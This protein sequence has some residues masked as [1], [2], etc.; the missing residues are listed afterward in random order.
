[1]SG[2]KRATAILCNEGLDTIGK[3]YVAVLKSAVAVHSS[4]SVSSMGKK[5]SRKVF[6]HRLLGDED[7][8]AK[9]SSLLLK[10]VSAFDELQAR[11]YFD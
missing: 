3:L 2:G 7:L 1:M 11:V 4:P 10:L 6:L 8:E 5:G 9:I